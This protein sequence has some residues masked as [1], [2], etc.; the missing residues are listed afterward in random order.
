MA[1]DGD[2][3]EAASSDNNS[4]SGS[5]DDFSVDSGSSPNT[6]SGFPPTVD[7]PPDIQ[8]SP[9]APNYD[10]VIRDSP[11][12]PIPTPDQPVIRE[13]T[14][15]DEPPLR[16]PDDDEPGELHTHEEDKIEIENEPEAGGD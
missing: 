11:P 10:Q 2:D 5:S 1:M 16:S 3:E 7:N 8:I 14:L 12:E 9:D 15:D 4:N 13:R 6:A